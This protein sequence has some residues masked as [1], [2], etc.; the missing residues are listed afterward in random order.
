MYAR[1]SIYIYI[2]MY[3]H[4][5]HTHAYI[6]SHTYIHT[7]IHT[8]TKHNVGTPSVASTPS[9]QNRY[10]LRSAMLTRT[11]KFE[12]IRAFNA[13]IKEGQDLAPSL[14]CIRQPHNKLT[15]DML[16]R[17]R[18]FEKLKAYHAKLAEKQDDDD[19]V[20]EIN[21]APNTCVDTLLLPKDYEDAVTG[22]YR[23]YW[24]TAIAE[25]IQN[26]I[27]Y[28]V[29]KVEEMS[30]D[31]VPVRGKFVF[32]W[33]P[34]ERNHLHKAKARFCMQGYRQRKGLHYD[35]TYVSVVFA[36]SLRVT[37][38]L[39][40]ELDFCIDVINL[41]AAYLT[42]D[43]EPDITLF[44]DPPP[45]VKVKEGYGLR[46]V[47][48]L[49]DSMQGAQRLDVLKHSVLEKLGFNRM[50]SET[51]VYYT[52]ASSDLGLTL[53]VTVVDDFVIVTRNRKIMA[54]V[55]HRLRK[56]W[57]IVDKGPIQ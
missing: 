10:R 13:A 11:R 36:S 47:K 14:E 19:L 30:P 7:Y 39:G 45:N 23:A 1:I 8:Y 22:P 26:L 44:I 21:I 57:T 52:P 20:P 4:V 31:A 42:A 28:K 43:I 55:K 53:I 35:K 48:A 54:E 46:L 24:I 9:S 34:D 25:E 56:V 18:I 6:Y 51:S 29:W 33:K 41:K 27:N 49:Y 5:Q 17:M 3:L 38:K 32:K 12:R 16:R 2:Y 50:L 37:L 40:V 15:P